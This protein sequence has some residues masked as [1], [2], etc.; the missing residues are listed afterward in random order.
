MNDSSSVLRDASSSGEW[1]RSTHECRRIAS[2]GSRRSKA[3]PP[4]CVSLPAHAGCSSPRNWCSRTRWN[5]DPKPYIWTKTAD[6]ILEKLAAYCN[7]INA[8]GR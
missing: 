2:D 1:R 8:S 3:R 5:D 4:R 6:E 7:T